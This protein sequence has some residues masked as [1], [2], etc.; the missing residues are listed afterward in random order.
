MTDFLTGLPLPPAAGNAFERAGFWR[1]ATA[2][3]VDLAIATLLLQILAFVLYPATGGRVQFAGGFMLLTCDKL[4]AVP[5]GFKLP[6][7]FVPTSIVECRQGLFGLT[8]ARTLQLTQVWQNGALTQSKYI[9]F[10]RDAE[11]RPVTHSILGEA[12]L[13]LFFLLRLLFDRRRGTPGRRLLG[14]RLAAAATGRT[15]PPSRDVTRRYLLQALPFAPYIILPVLMHLFGIEIVPFSIAGL[16]LMIA[17]GLCGGAGLLIALYAIVKRRDAFYD[18]RAGTAVPRIVG[19]SATAPSAQPALPPPAVV[20]DEPE[21]ADAVVVQPPPLPRPANYV[22]RHWRGELPLPLSFW[23]NDIVLGVAFSIP[24]ALLISLAAQRSGEQPLLWLVVLSMVWLLIALLRVWQAVGIWRAA[25]RYD[26]NGLTFWGGAAKLATVG[27]LL[28]FAY[29]FVVAAIPQLA[30]IYEIVAGDALVGPHQFRVLAN[31]RTLEFSGG[32]TFG[33]A[34]EMENFLGAMGNIRT[35][36][37]NSTGGRMLEAQKMADLIKARELTTYVAQDC[38]SA[39]T[40]VFLGGKDRVLLKGRGRL[41][42]HQVRFAGMTSASRSLAMSSEIARLE[43]FGLSHAFAE[44]AMSALPSSMWYPDQ[45]ELLR[46]KVATRLFTPPL[47]PQA[48]TADATASEPAPAP[49]E[50]TPPA[51][52]AADHAVLAPAPPR[53]TDSARL[54]SRSVSLPT[55]LVKRLTPKA[56]VKAGATEAK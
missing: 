56:A 49:A 9:T 7:D 51:D 53:Q 10:L 19:R 38:L 39:C 48:S 46:E 37:L 11:G 16:I 32:I 18:S 5:E 22:V 21:V 14:V 24:L 54:E 33:V 30:G 34:K 28:Y 17:P 20:P 15:P 23:V 52:T 43:R 41:G 44:R 8:S 42:F 36:R 29:S 3:L 47:K 50:P 27:M 1:R 26:A 31:G 25:S 12:W 6:G 2:L 4:D 45:D 40:V 13:A 55:E 35:V